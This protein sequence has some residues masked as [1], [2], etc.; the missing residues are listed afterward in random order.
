VVRPCVGHRREIKGR[1]MHKRELLG[2]RLTPMHKKRASRGSFQHHVPT[3][4]TR[5]NVIMTT[6]TT[7]DNIYGCLESEG[8]ELLTD[9]R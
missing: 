8:F 1:L 4:K 2:M 9:L 6:P 7:N 5:T 3:R